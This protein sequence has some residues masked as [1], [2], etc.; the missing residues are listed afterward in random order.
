MIVRNEERDLGRCLASVTGVVDEIVVVDTGSTDRTAAIAA[1]YGARLLAHAWRDD[2]SAA[3]NCALEHAT[4]RWILVLDADEVLECEGGAAVRMVIRHSACDGLRVRMRN[5][6]R[7][8]DLCAYSDCR[9][10]RLFRNRAEYRYEGTVHEQIA[11]AILRVGG[12]LGDAE[13]TVVHHGYARRVAQGACDRAARNVRLLKRALSATPDDAYLHYQM[14]VTYRSAKEPAR[15]EHHLRHALRLDRG[16][17]DPDARDAAWMALGQI[18][19]G[20]GR[21]DDALRCAESS[22]RL[23]PENTLSLYVA[24]LASIERGEVRKAYEYFCRLRQRADIRL[25]RRGDIETLVKHFRAVLGV[26]DG[27]EKANG[28]TG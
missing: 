20:A 27:T 24:A 10:T 9:L 5:V 6:Q 18:A 25:E 3:R 22:L 26:Q 14:G 2:F 13:L 4:G 12:T 15:A 7:P 19:L 17:L 1:A 16:T 21:R 23:N 11:P 28:R 8:D